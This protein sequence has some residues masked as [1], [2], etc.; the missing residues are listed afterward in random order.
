MGIFLLYCSYEE[1]YWNSRSHQAI[2]YWGYLYCG[3]SVYG[4]DVG[5]EN[6]FTGG[7]GILPV[8][9]GIQLVFVVPDYW[10]KYLPH[11]GIDL[12]AQ[13]SKD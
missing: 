3:G 9:G 6:Y 7:W 13:M 11:S 8:S 10:Q 4:A 2:H 5:M 12:L 1:K